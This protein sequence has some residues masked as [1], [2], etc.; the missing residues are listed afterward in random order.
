MGEVYIYREKIRISEA[1]PGS[2]NMWIIVPIFLL[3]LPL[4]QM[5]VHFSFVVN[6]TSLSL[7]KFIE[8]YINIYK[9]KLV[10]NSK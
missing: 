4:F 2:S 5:I 9:I 6:Q 8:K 7:T 10:L 1:K 3:L